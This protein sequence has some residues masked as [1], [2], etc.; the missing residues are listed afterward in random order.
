MFAASGSRSRW[1]ASALLICASIWFAGLEYRGLFMPD[2][3]RY[4]DIAREMLDADDWVTP[5][6]NGIKYLEKP[7][8]QYWATAG[9]FSVLG[10]DE[11]TARLWPAY[12]GFLGIALTAFAGFRLAPRSPWLPTA[13]TLAGCW[14]YFLG[15]QFLTL[16]M[17]LTFFLTVAMLGFL[18]SRRAG[19]PLAEE[20]GWMIFAWAGM[21][22]AVL[23]KG[24]VGIVIPGLALLVYVALE[25]E[26]SLLRRL[27]WVPGLC[28][29]GAIALPWFVLAQ[30]R[31]PEFFHFFFIREHLERY[32]LP[33]HHR[34]GPWW[35]FVPVLLVGLLPWT[36]SIPAAFARAWRTSAAPGFKLDRFLVIW[37]GVVV[38]FFSASHSKLPGYI[39]PAVPAILLLF[40]RHYPALSERLRRA[41]AFTCVAS[42][43]VLTL[44][45]AALPA[46]SAPL[47]WTEL[48]AEFSVW[49]LAA[50]LALSAAG[51]AALRLLRRSRQEASLAVL[52]LGSLLAVQIALSGTHVLD[53][54]YS[55]ER[56]VEAVVGDTKRFPREPPFYSVAS[57]DQ[58]VPF[59]LGRPV[60]LV[61]YK[62]E[63]APGIAAEPGKYVGSVDEFLRRWQEHPEAFAIM[64]PHFYE[65]LRLQGL[66]G[67]VLARDA[68]RVIVA[69]R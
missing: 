51:L 8:L 58:S 14:G 25:R 28:V 18:L 6:L 3:G 48:N 21:A 38:V 22:C 26:L 2:E 23:S 12:T 40:A 66:P 37:T 44:L 15:A 20:R 31:N 30:H 45:A 47:A 16:D 67:R 7:P 68:R 5:R 1:I 41:P 55:S 36:P 32:L 60:T 42:G 4:A 50:G 59:Y 57:F 11:W 17:G 52:G 39:L 27:H 43:L 56:L 34:P 46:L 13:V 19:I 61:G 35:Y 64:T 24:I 65:K 49:L 9:A 10:V 63:L 62:D 69:R 54:R 33:D 53:E 29:F